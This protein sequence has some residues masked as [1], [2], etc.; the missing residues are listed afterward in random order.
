[1]QKLKKFQPQKQKHRPNSA[2]FV[3]GAT[4]QAARSFSFYQGTIT[5][6]ASYTIT[7]NLLLNDGAEPTLLKSQLNYAPGSYTSLSMRLQNVL[8]VTSRSTAPFV[9]PL[10]ENTQWNTYKKLLRNEFYVLSYFFIFLKA[11]K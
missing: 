2:S 9:D 4:W 6:C 10:H 8:H 11:R 1:V 3:I 5:I 7:N